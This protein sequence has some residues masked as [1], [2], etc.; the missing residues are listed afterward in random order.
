MMD[1]KKVKPPDIAALALTVLLWAC[2]HYRILFLGQTEV[3]LDSSRFFYP[4]W[5]WGAGVWDRG[6]I[7]LWNPDAAFGTPYLAD[8]DMAAWYPPLRA[9]YCFFPPTTAFNLL[10]VGHHLWAL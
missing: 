7:P 4:L 8:P 1:F 5:K 2:F 10:V 6:W 9:C 3:L